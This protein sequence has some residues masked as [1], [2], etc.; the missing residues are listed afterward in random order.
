MW[1]CISLATCLGIAFDFH[2]MRS[3]I[4][5]PRDP[6]YEEVGTGAGWEVSLQKDLIM[7]QHQADLMNA[8][9]AESE[10]ISAAIFQ[11]IGQFSQKNRGWNNSMPYI[12]MPISPHNFTELVHIILEMMKAHCM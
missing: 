10:Q 3:E 12:L 8:V 6:E 4:R 1:P 5:D 11:N 2:P 7:Q 9:A